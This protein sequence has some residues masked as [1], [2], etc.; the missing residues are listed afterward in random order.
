MLSDGRVTRSFCY[1]ADAVA[2]LLLVLALDGAGRGV[3]LGNDEEVTIADLAQVVDEVSGNGLGVALR[4]ERRSC[5]PRR[6]PF[7]PLA[8]PDG[9]SRRRWAGGPPSGCARGSQR[10]LAYYRAGAAG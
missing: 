10:T 5:L 6:Q 7:A 1:V 4:D 2:A 9:S 8:G 3:Q